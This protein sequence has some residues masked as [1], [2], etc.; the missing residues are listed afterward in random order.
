MSNRAVYLRS[1]LFR[2][3]HPWLKKGV[4]F[5][6]MA[7]LTVWGNVAN[8]YPPNYQRYIIGERAIGMG[9]AYAAAGNDPIMSYY[10]PGGLAFARSSMISVS[11]NLYSLDYRKIEGGFNPSV[12]REV[13]AITLEHDHDLSFPS[14]LAVLIHFGGFKKKGKK[15]PPENHTVSLT[16]ITPYQD[17][18]NYDETW[19]SDTEERDS[20]TYQVK[21]TYRIVWTGLSYAYRYG[22]KWGFG[23][24]AFLSDSKYSRDL[25]TNWIQ[26]AEGEQE[27]PPG[28]CGVIQTK[29]SDFDL[30]VVSFLF[31]VGVVW[32]PIK[33]WRFGLAV[34]TPNIQVKRFIFRK[35]KGSLDQIFSIGRAN[36]DGQDFVQFYA[37]DYDFG[38]E[39]HEP[40]IFRL[41]AAYFGRKRS[42]MSMDVSLYIPIPSVY[43]RVGGDPVYKRRHP[44]GPDGPVDETASPDWVDNGIV[45]K[46]ERLPV[47]NV[48]LGG[49]WAVIRHWTVRSGIYTDFSAAP[50]VT[51][52]ATPQETRV[53]RFGATYSIGYRAKGL[54]LTLGITG[55]YGRGKASV[56]HSREP[57]DSRQWQP[58]GYTEYSVYVFIA[59]ITKAAEKSSKA[60]VKKV[61][62]TSTGA[63][64]KKK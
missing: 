54:D 55:T 60:I 7:F 12:N 19:V 26:N 21:E 43:Y 63:E 5:L 28:R 64:A 42:V 41:G 11:Q 23:V 52:S 50:K 59:G 35:T 18:F 37:D 17:S 29:E 51:Y 56:Y 16:M 6:T 47:V 1:G 34:T 49:E 62:E 14:T 36:N 38:V 33:K 30:K 57:D 46:I 8:T 27:C 31:K 25:N 15:K 61:E 53:Q 4:F 13:N 40:L 39:E 22:N 48:N 45:K 24:S 58:A 9:G 10:N 20:Q 3:R 44:E 2:N 32:K